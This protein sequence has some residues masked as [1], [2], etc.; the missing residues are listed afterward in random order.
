LWPLESEGGYR[1]EGDDKGV[2]TL[3]KRTGLR[4]PTNR[5]IVYETPP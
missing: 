3:H 2:K 1:G 5:L 4:K